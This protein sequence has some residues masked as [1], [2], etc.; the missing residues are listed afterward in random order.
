[1]FFSVVTLVIRH[2]PY[3]YIWGLTFIGK[4]GTGA[5]QAEGPITRGDLPFKRFRALSRIT[6]YWRIADY[7][8]CIVCLT[9][10]AEMHVLWEEDSWVAMKVKRSLLNNIEMFCHPAESTVLCWNYWGSPLL[11]QLKISLTTSF[12]SHNNHS[13]WVAPPTAKSPFLIKCKHWYSALV[14]SPF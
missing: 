9:E 11:P 4:F 14:L 10:S 3:I 1:M 12:A 13:A 2:M 7:S 8:Y 6:K 5:T